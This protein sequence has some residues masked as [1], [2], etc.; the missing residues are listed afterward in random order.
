MDQEEDIA[1]RNKDIHTGDH[2]KEYQEGSCLCRKPMKKRAQ[3][4]MGAQGWMSLGV[5]QGK[6]NDALEYVEN[7]IDRPEAETLQLLEKYQFVCSQKI[8]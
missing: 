5:H 6:K 8:K 1:S 4:K 3:T 2:Q 7:N